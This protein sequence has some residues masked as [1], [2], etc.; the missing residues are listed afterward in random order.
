MSGYD[1][2]IRGGTI[3][4]GSGG[5]LRE[6]DVAIRGGLIVAVGKNLARG[7]DEIDAGG[8]LVTPGFVDIHT[9]YDGQV[10]WTDTLE[11]S[12]DHGVTTVVMGNCG[13]GFAPCRPT[14][15][16]ALIKL[17]EG[18][19]DLPEAVLEAGVPWDWEDFGGY[20]DFLGSR[21][22]NI[23][24]AAQ[25]PHAPVRVYVM[26]ERAFAREAST[27]ADNAAMADIVAD[28]IRAGALGFTTSRSFNHKGSDGR[29]TPTLNA[30]EIELTTIARAVGDCGTGV[31]EAILD[32]VDPVAE[33][34]MF[35]RIARA[36]GRPMSVSVMQRHTEPE[37]WRDV[38]AWVDRFNT[39]G[40][41]FR[42]QVSERPVGALYGLDISFNPLA[43]SALYAPIA[44]LSL[45]ERVAR[46]SDPAF[47]ARMLED[48]AQYADAMKIDKMFD[49]GNPPCYEP[50]PD[51]Y[52]TAMAKAR[53]V[54][55]LEALYDLLLSDGGKAIIAQPGSNLGYGNLDVCREMMLHPHTVMGLADGGAHLGILC[56]A[57]QQTHMLAYW[58]RDRKHDRIPVGK[59]V[60][61]LSRE[62]AAAVGLNDRGLIAP[63]MRAD[64]NVIDYDNLSFDRP[65][66]T[67]DL[68][69]GGRRLS[70]PSRGYVATLVAGEVIVRNDQ[71]TGARPGRL[72]RGARGVL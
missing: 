53:N 5:E 12:S 41:E 68:P 23:D 30:T 17:M 40:V 26:G 58:T 54:S 64:I 36:S 2:V 38:M 18:V 44:N 50:G 10:T 13:V 62:T 43:R 51:R 9:H 22:Y 65:V 37:Q 16:R 71:D 66:A 67:Y 56:D 69:E 8:L 70:Q 20:M 35:G 11:P 4:D 31:L 6:A 14:D 27:D 15:R 33:M 24:I 57:S 63:G 32:P 61:L 46:L 49:L 60:S 7:R 59:A 72:V 29:G 39:E 55:P 52:V 34:E 45:A 28:A 21:I 25:V 47:R 42:G 19:E 3:A 48:L 1:C